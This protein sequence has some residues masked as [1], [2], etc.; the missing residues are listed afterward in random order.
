MKPYIYICILKKWSCS[1]IW[2]VAIGSIG[3]ALEEITQENRRCM[4][5]GGR[6]EVGVFYNLRRSLTLILVWGTQKKQSIHVN[7]PRCCSSSLAVNR[8]PH[9]VVLY[10]R[11]VF[12]YQECVFQM[13]FLMNKKQHIVL[14]FKGAVVLWSLKQ[15]FRE[16]NIIYITFSC[17][18]VHIVNMTYIFLM[19]FFSRRLYKVETELFFR[20]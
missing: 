19:T 16:V 8:P 1:F 3:A 11:E 17:Y 2:G 14:L 9:N 5:V 20:E 4:C 13:F 7:S 10:S 6:K 15:Y 18:I 12:I